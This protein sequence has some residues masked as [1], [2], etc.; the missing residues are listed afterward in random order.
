MLVDLTRELGA[1]RLLHLLQHGVEVE[2][3]IGVQEVG[4]DSHHRATQKIAALLLDDVVLVLHRHLHLVDDHGEDVEEASFSAFS[5][6]LRSDE[7]ASP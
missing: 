4:E 7:V 1:A 5:G 2:A 3:G 6:G